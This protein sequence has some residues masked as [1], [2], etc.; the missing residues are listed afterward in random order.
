MKKKMITLLLAGIMAFSLSACGETQDTNEDKKETNADT[1]TT[2]QAEKTE[3]DKNTL[4]VWAWDQNF[5][6]YA[7]K[8][9]EKIYQKDHPDFKLDIVELT[10]GDV[11]TKI[12]TAALADDTSILPD[13]FLLQDH[14]YQKF[15][16][17]YPDIFSDLSD[18]GIPFDQFSESKVAESMKDGKNYAVPFDNGA[19]VAAY[20]TDILADAGLSLDDFTDITW[21][22]FI[23]L[24]EQVK[25]KTGISLLSGNG[26]SPELVMMMMRSTGATAFHDDGSVNMVDNESL[27]AAMNVYIELVQ[28]GILT[29]VTDWDQYVGSLNSGSAACAINGCWI[30]GSIQG[31]EDQSGKWGITNMPALDNIK[32]AT[33]YSSNGGSSWAVSSTSKNLDLAVDFL[34]KTFA[35]SVELYETILPK[36]GAL[37]TWLPMKDSDVYNE[38]QEYYGGQAVYT[39]IVG[40]AEK[41]PVS[42]RGTY[43]YDAVDAVGVAVSNIIQ[44]GADFESELKQAQDTV[45]FNMNN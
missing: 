11:E 45:A 2:P 23:E 4:M 43:Y 6:I 14:T 24:G 30:S 26:G 16:E 15:L 34:G 17:S 42:V 40:F 19:C 39:D 21:S 5:N 25:E 10:S 33:N 7:M 44:T 9:A 41:V 35:G 22:K 13:I 38:G 29:E 31:A 8:E 36:S 18:S 20:R 1:E 37:A 28:K 12:A 27:R 32:G 3:D